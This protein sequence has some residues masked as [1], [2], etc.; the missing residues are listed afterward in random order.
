MIIGSQY[1]I[2]LSQT[3]GYSQGYIDSGSY[4]GRRAFQ[5]Y[6]VASGI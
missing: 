1:Q 5:L 4:D 2:R 3:I 6:P